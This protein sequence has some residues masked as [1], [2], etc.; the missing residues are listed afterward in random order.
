MTMTDD[1]AGEIKRLRR[2]LAELNLVERE[3]RVE[4]ERLQILEVQQRAE[5]ARLEHALAQMAIRQA[6]I[7][8]QWIGEKGGGLT[9]I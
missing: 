9:P 8:P 3:R 2:Q 4:I 1:A 5:I 6:H 7:P